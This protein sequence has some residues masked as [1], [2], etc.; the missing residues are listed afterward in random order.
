MAPGRKPS[1]QSRLLASACKAFIG[2]A[3]DD[4]T[5]DVDT[6]LAFSSADSRDTDDVMLY[7]ALIA[8]TRNSYEDWKKI[9]TV[10]TEA[11]VQRRSSGKVPYVL[12]VGRWCSGGRVLSSAMIALSL[13]ARIRY[14]PL[15]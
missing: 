6:A 1:P 5:L 2:F 11:A 7:F 10:V 4:C 8:I 14:M 9:Y 12:P 13:E 3:Q 15:K